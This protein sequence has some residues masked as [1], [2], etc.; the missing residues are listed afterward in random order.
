MEYIRKVTTVGD[1]FVDLTYASGN[2]GIVTGFNYGSYSTYGKVT[3]DICYI[4]HGTTYLAN[5]TNSYKMLFRNSANSA[6]RAYWLASR[7]VIFYS[8]DCSF[9]V[10]HVDIGHVNGYYLCNSNYSNENERSRA[11]S[12]VV[13]L[14]S[15]I[16]LTWDSTNNRWNIN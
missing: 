8:S 16:Q 15:N 1:Y 13:Y 9:Y 6:D 3:G 12:P 11:V 5:T 2:T 14:N 10:R 7:C 4:Y